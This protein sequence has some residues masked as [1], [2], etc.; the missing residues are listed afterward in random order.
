MYIN[1]IYSGALAAAYYL[2]V[3]YNKKGHK[4]KETAECSLLIM[5]LNQT[6]LVTLPER[7]QRVQA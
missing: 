3:K 1:T 5:R 6:A 4:E 2:F 7:R